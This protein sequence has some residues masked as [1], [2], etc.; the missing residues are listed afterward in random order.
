MKS[1]KHSSAGFRIQSPTPK[2]GERKKNGI[3]RRLTIS[4]YQN[5]LRD[6]LGLQEDVCASLP[7]DGISKDGFVN[8]AAG[9]S[10]SPLLIEAYFNIAA[11][12]LDR[13]IVDVDSRPSI[14]NFRM[15]LGK[16]INQQPCPDKLILGAQNRLL[17]NADFI[18]RQ[19]VPGKPFPF[20]PITMRTKFRFNEGYQGNATVRGWRDYDSIYHAVFACMRGT[21]GYPKG[22][23]HETVPGGLLLRPAIPSSE[24]F[25]KSSTYGPMANFKIS[26]R[27]L[28]DH[29]NFRITVRAARYDDGLLL[30]GDTPLQP[31]GPKSI[32]IDQPSQPQTVNV[33][34]AGI[35]QVDVRPSLPKPSPKFDATQLNEGL[36]A[37][38]S[39]D[40][41]TVGR[42]GEAELT[43][44][45]EGEAQLGDSPFGKALRVNGQAGAL[46]VPRGDNIQIG[47]GEFTVAAWIYP[48][49]LRQSGIVCLGGYGYTHG[50]LLDMPDGRGTLRLE[51]ARSDN[52]SNGTVKSRRGVIS[53]NRWQHVAVT[54]NRQENGTRLFVNGHH[55]GRGTIGDADLD[56]PNVS[57]NIGRI[58]GAQVFHGAIDDVRLVPSGITARKRFTR[59][60]SRD[61]R[62][63]LRRAA[64]I[65]AI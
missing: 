31:L 2:A 53:V 34:S 57:L 10:L 35:Y 28:P 17:A 41:D 43:G 60:S 15:D 62:S 42:S 4:Q 39:F 16:A 27:Q 64:P 55:V 21:P 8:N 30:D 5:T 24:L 49:H 54:S 37:A 14:Q 29:G 13:C 3:I 59:W 61:V 6:L 63:P 7:P 26:L 9:M 45:T 11:Q 38:W 58:Q 65:R 46:V 32:V 36:I 20:D 12:A 22:Q 23:A 44:E 51:T 40:D 56:N 50:W 48:R 19:V 1:V 33:P 18:V 25:G 47:T 52:Q